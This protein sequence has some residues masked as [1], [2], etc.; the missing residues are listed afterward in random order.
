MPILTCPSCGDKFNVADVSGG[1]SVRCPKCRKSFTYVGDG[2]KQKLVLAGAVTAVLVLFIALVWFFGGGSFS[3]REAHEKT[4][5][6]I[7]DRARQAE[8]FL[9]KQAQKNPPPKQ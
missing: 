4:Q 2:M 9:Q 6:M 1:E 3:Q 7:E 8:E 5:Q